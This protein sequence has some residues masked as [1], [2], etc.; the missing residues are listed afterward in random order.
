MPLSE[1]KQQPW[2]PHFEADIPNSSVTPQEALRL[3]MEGNER[4]VEGR[5]HAQT[6]MERRAGF[7]AGQSPMAAVLCCADSRVAPEILFDQPLG[8]IFSVRVAGNFLHDD[9]L[10][11]LEYA[12]LKLGT[13]LIFVL[14]HTDCG[15]V[16]AA[17]GTLQENLPLPG[18][19]PAL[20][21]S[22]MPAVHAALQQHPANALDACIHTNVAFEVRDI[23]QAQPVIAPMA[24][25]GRVLVVGGVARVETG[26]VE[27]MEA[28]G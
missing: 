13:P 26:V 18:R 4:F 2:W 23:A 27:L 9:G 22:L 14:G 12:V 24:A 21:G 6:T 20:V 11:S 19:L 3:L 5:P 15:A 25:A 17:M 8:E 7:A 16:K 1:L 10:A 28:A